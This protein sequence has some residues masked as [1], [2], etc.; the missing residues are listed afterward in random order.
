MSVFSTEKTNFRFMLVAPKVTLNFGMLELF[1][2]FTA[3]C[4]VFFEEFFWM[5]S[6]QT[7][8]NCLPIMVLVAGLVNSQMICCFICSPVS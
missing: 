6:L 5:S 1:K 4:L 7:L 2:H 3:S 8:F